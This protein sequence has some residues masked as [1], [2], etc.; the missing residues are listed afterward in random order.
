VIIRDSAKRN[1]ARKPGFNFN[2][3]RGGRIRPPASAASTPD[4]CVRGHVSHRV[5]PGS[6]KKKPQ[7]CGWG[8]AELRCLE[9]IPQELV[10]YLV[11]K[12]HFLRLDERPQGAR[13]AV[14]GGLL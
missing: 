3:H 14:G 11:M 8:M 2:P 7:P 10:V 13:A 9:E 1:L 6:P 4:E 5:A 12:L